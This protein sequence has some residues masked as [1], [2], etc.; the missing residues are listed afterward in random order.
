[1]P[2]CALSLWLM[3]KHNWIPLSRLHPPLCVCPPLSAVR[4][5]WLT[6]NLLCFLLLNGRHMYYSTDL[7]SPKST[8]FQAQN[9]YHLD[10][11]CHLSLTITCE[12]SKL[13]WGCREQGTE[14]QLFWNFKQ[15]IKKCEPGSETY[16]HNYTFFPPRVT[17]QPLN[18]ATQQIKFE[19]E[20]NWFFL[21]FW[22]ITIYRLIY[23]NLAV[24]PK[25]WF[26]KP[27]DKE[28]RI[29]AFYLK[30]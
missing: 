28:M 14:A 13:K 30:V 10:S 18:N 3:H 19:L 23:I 6:F 5:V 25:M 26:L 8:L 24:T 1:M 21:I 17:E 2:A 29:E 20:P 22:L 9:N 16:R 12:R 27:Y 15:Y 7:I 4:A 11:L